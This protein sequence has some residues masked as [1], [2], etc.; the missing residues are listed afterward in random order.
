MWLWTR[1]ALQELASTGQICQR[2]PRI[3]NLTCQLQGLGT[4]GLPLGN[5]QLL[6]ENKVVPEAPALEDET[7]AQGWAHAVSG[8]QGPQ[9][10]KMKPPQGQTHAVSGSQGPGGSQR[11]HLR[12]EAQ[13]CPCGW[14]GARPRGCTL[15]DGCTHR[16]THIH[17]HVHTHPRVHTSGPAQG[18]ALLLLLG[19]P[20][21]PARHRPATQR[22]RR[23][24]AGAELPPT[25]VPAPPLPQARAHEPS[26]LA[27]PTRLWPVRSAQTRVAGPVGGLSGP[28]STQATSPHALRPSFAP[29]HLPHPA[30]GD[31]TPGRCR[32]KP[33][34]QLPQHSATTRFTAVHRPVPPS[35]ES[36]DCFSFSPSRVGLS[37]SHTGWKPPVSNLPGAS[38]SRGPRTRRADLLSSSKC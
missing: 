31:P 12:D 15:P 38:L 17:S 27:L 34:S 30:P 6:S 9:P 32:N 3:C 24:R 20:H 22:P 13:R 4:W 23:T 36:R 28:S 10:S 16:H 1:E 7:P 35:A 37:A 2:E 11:P 29:A 14:A 8:S 5:L 19:D 18:R 33:G 26:V 25:E 21:P